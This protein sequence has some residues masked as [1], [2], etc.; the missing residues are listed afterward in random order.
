[1]EKTKHYLLATILFVIVAFAG[2]SK[3]DDDDDDQT[4]TPTPTPVTVNSAPQVTGLMDGAAFS[5]VTGGVS[6]YQS[7]LSSDG[8]IA[9]P[10]DE[11][12]F[13]LGAGIENA[14]N[15]K[16][17][18]FNMGTFSFVTPSDTSDLKTFFHIGVWPY[19]DQAVNGVQIRYVDGNGDF[20]ST[21]EFPADQTGSTFTIT[22]RKALVNGGDNYMKIKAS[23][24]CKLYNGFGDV[25]NITGGTVVATFWCEY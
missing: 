7:T 18:D 24:K 23:F 3:G 4:P 22:E 10:P 1:M 14:L 6:A 25:K 19:S 17:M 16:Y 12:D 13:I 15:G 21:D 11:S 8:S 20:W 9:I 2:C 5:W